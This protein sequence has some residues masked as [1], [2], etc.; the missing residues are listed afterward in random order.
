MY[1]VYDADDDAD[2]ERRVYPD[3]VQRRPCG[4]QR[5]DAGGG[6]DGVH[7]VRHADHHVLFDA[8]HA[9]DHAAQGQCVGRAYRGGF[10]YRAYD[11]RSG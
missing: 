1:D 2:H 7:P 3:R 8:D 6:Y 4:G 10:G 5:D 11:L 9:L